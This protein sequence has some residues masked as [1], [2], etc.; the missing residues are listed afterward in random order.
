MYGSA[1]SKDYLSY[2]VVYVSSTGNQFIKSI[3]RIDVPLITYCLFIENVWYVF[4]TPGGCM[5]VQAKRKRAHFSSII[6]H[7][8]FGSPL[9]GSLFLAPKD[10]QNVA[11]CRRGQLSSGKL[12]WLQ[13]QISMMSFFLL[14]V[15]SCHLLSTCSGNILAS[16][17]R[18]PCFSSLVPTSLTV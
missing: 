16:I 3:S 15:K 1:S 8:I 9:L 6:N 4:F 12:L 11:Q 10:C 13:H 5:V 14:L 17:A 7:L 18:R 2:S